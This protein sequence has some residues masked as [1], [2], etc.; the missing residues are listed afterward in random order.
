VVS[1]VIDVRYW[2]VRHNPACVFTTVFIID[3]CYESLC[4]SAIVIRHCIYCRKKAGQ[5]FGS[6]IESFITPGTFSDLD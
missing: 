5:I 1:G 6:V 2:T 4:E 3:L